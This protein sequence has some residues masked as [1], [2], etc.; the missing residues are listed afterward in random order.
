MRHRWFTAFDSV[1]Q[2][3]RDKLSQPTAS[4]STENLLQRNGNAG[5]FVWTSH[6]V[7]SCRL[8]AIQHR[9][10]RSDANNCGRS[11]PPPIA[12]ESEY[13]RVKASLHVVSA[14]IEC[15]EQ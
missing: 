6:C 10:V 15:S 1:A 9:L 7:E 11:E 4:P 14:P 8:S 3:T 12:P 5:I 13:V 2:H